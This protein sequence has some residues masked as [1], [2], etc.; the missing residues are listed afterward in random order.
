MTILTG[1]VYKA[2]TAKELQNKIGIDPREFFKTLSK[3]EQER[4]IEEYNS[5]CSDWD[6]EPI[7]EIDNLPEFVCRDWKE[8]IVHGL[9]KSNFEPIITAL[10]AREAEYHFLYHSRTHIVIEQN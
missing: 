8:W 5:L 3:P 1:E 10:E 7:E 9:G 4:L 2:T 6:E